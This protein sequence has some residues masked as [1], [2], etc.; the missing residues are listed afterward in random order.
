MPGYV[1]IYLVL[2]FL[3]A[4]RF[5]ILKEIDWGWFFLWPVIAFFLKIII[6]LL[7]LIIYPILVFG[8]LWLLAKL[9]FLTF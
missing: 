5:P 4:I 3:R 2:L 6:R 7:E 8:F 1:S 9:Y